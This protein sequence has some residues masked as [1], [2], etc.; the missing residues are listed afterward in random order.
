M[1][2]SVAISQI[3][4]EKSSIKFE[5]LI[6][7]LNEIKKMPYFRLKKLKMAFVGVRGAK[8]FQQRRK[9]ELLQYNYDLYEIIAIMKEKKLIDSFSRTS[10]RVIDRS[11]LNDFIDSYLIQ[12]NEIY[13]RC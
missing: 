2:D 1:I 8:T 10:F 3:E 13:N 12:L 4:V 11:K 5:F 7:S 9:L 6:F